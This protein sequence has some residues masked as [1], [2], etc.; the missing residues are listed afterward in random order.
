MGAWQ[1]TMAATEVY[2]FLDAED[3]IFWHYRKGYHDQTVIDTDMLVNV[4]LHI[5]KGEEL[6]DAFYHTPFK[7]PELMLDWRC[8]QNKGKSKK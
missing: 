7:K 5:Y 3:R 6:D 8:P 2:K 4:I 1:T